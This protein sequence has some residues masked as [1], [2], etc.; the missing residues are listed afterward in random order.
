MK[1][2]LKEAEKHL[3]AGEHRFGSAQK[4]APGTGFEVA[5]TWFTVLDEKDKRGNRKVQC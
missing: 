2:A 3:I 5:G 4:G 1:A